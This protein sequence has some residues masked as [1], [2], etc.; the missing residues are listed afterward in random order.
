MI[1]FIKEIY[2]PIPAAN[3]S[4]IPWDSRIIYLG[5][6]QQE[7]D[8]YNRYITFVQ[9]FIKKY[10]TVDGSQFLDWNVNRD[11]VRYAEIYEDQIEIL[12]F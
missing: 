9:D 8:Y 4:K 10:A 7:I 12:R 3:L 5:G 2:D 6:Y 1:T 11:L